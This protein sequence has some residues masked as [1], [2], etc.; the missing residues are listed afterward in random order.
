MSAASLASFGAVIVACLSAFLT[1]RATSQ[2]NRTAADELANKVDKE[3]YDR[4]QN[5]WERALNQS[6]KEVEK[7][8]AQIQRLEDQV[9]AKEELELLL[10]E[11]LREL[12]ATVARMERQNARMRV[13]LRAAGIA[14]PDPGDDSEGELR[15][16]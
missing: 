12:K 2:A 6:D 16:G 13:M 5:I 9:R 8:R 10:R 1:Y 7:L 11:Q 14:V 15:A 4:A 3:A